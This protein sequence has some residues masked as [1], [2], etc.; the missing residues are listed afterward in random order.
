MSLPYLDDELSRQIEPQAPPP[1]ER[2][3]ALLKGHQAGC[4]L[5]VAVAPT[6]PK[7]AL[8]DF[9][10]YFEKIMQFEPEVI[11]WEPINARGT[12]GK[13]MVAAGLEFANSIMTKNSW[14]ERFKTQWE[15]IE[16]AAK[17]IGCID[18][19][20]IWP[21]PELRGYVEDSKLDS[22]LYKPTVEKWDNL[23]TSKPKAKS[24]T[25]SRKKSQTT[26]A[27]S[28]SG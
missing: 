15:E 8:D 7:M 13:R 19:L 21:D 3:K 9:K 25:A 6:P 4:R 12:N 2:Y 23:T 5:Y 22:W 17:D 10:R 18:R 28:H 24:T 1:S 27:P 26:L 20:H 16:A 11:F 14:A